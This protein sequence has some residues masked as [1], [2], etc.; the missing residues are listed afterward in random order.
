[1]LLESFA[2]ACIQ[3]SN[4][5]FVFGELRFDDIDQ[6]PVG[7]VDGRL[8]F[9]SWVVGEIVVFDECRVVEIFVGFDPVGERSGENDL[10]ASGCQDGYGTL[11]LRQA[12]GDKLF[13]F[14]FIAS[15]SLFPIV[16]IR[17]VGFNRSKLNPTTL[18]YI[19][20]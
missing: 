8:S 15:I 9:E 6:D 7:M 3:D 18:I 17:V 20:Q 19:A 12:R 2:E 16:V 14:C 11:V 4:G 1:M 10:G 5:A 13:R